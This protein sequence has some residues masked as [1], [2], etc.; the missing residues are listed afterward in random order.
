MF[1][2]LVTEADE[3]EALGTVVFA[4]APTWNSVIV[5]TSPLVFLRCLHIMQRWSKH[6]QS[7]VQALLDFLD[8]SPKLMRVKHW[9]LWCLPLLFGVFT[10]WKHTT[11]FPYRFPALAVYSTLGRACQT[12]CHGN[13]LVPIGRSPSLYHGYNQTTVRHETLHEQLMIRLSSM[14]Q[15]IHTWCVFPIPGVPLLWWPNHSL[16]HWVACSIQHSWKLRTNQPVARMDNNPLWALRCSPR[17]GIVCD[18]LGAISRWATSWGL[19]M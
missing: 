12:T 14:K 7:S 18:L 17:F 10:A 2:G 6:P 5:S 8:W 9:G 16:E 19:S 4:S 15:L 3:G 1:I 13:W 11:G